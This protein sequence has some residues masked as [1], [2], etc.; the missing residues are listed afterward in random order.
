MI[1]LTTLYDDYIFRPKLT[2][3][4]THLHIIVP[5]PQKVG[6]NKNSVFN[7][8]IHQL[9]RIIWNIRYTTVSLR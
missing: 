7:K 2:E 3:Q 5:P 8:K 1:P 6:W 9:L 4:K